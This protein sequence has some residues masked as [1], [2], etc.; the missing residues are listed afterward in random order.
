MAASSPQSRAYQSMGTGWRMTIWDPLSEKNFDELMEEILKQSEKFDGTYSR[1]K[2]ESLVWSLSRQTGIITVP[3]DLV[4]MLRIYEE[5]SPLCDNVLNPLVGFALSDLGYDAE[6]SMQ[7][8]ATIRAIPELR[9]ALTIVDDT[10]IELHEPVLIDLG[11]VGKGY[12]VDVIASMLRERGFKRFL[13]DGSGDISYAGNDQPIRAGLEDPDDATKAI[14]VVTMTS[15]VMCASGSNKRRWGNYHHIINPATLRS[16]DE[17]R[18]TW[19]IADSAAMADGLA[20]CLF[21][22]DPEPIRREISFEYCIM[23]RENKVKTSPG[24]AAE[25]FTG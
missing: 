4:N 10:T 17:V 14:G 25:I 20:T 1:F 13:V 8:K 2:K 21:L 7:T 23:N 18:A 9:K 22:A 3:Q 16:A 19:V 24:F 6:Y 12:F 15:G 11:A 5:L